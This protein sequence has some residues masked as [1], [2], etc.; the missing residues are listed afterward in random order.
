MALIKCKI[1]Q[2]LP[3]TLCRKVTSSMW[4]GSL[5]DP[6]CIPSRCQNHCV[7][8][9]DIRIFFKKVIKVFSLCRY[10]LLFGKGCD[11]SL[12]QT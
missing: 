2:H 4:A 8:Y 1:M 12:E 3:Q 9:K 7:I 5:S 10:Y 11:P 6:V